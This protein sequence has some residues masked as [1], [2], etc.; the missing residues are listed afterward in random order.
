MIQQ[1]QHHSRINKFAVAAVH[2]RWIMLI[3]VTFIPCIV[4]CH[5]EADLA[6]TCYWDIDRAS[7]GNYNLL[8]IKY[9]LSEARLRYISVQMTGVPRHDTV[10][11]EVRSNKSHFRMIFLKKIRKHQIIITPEHEKIVE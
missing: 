8:C 9:V 6:T 2:R 7:D 5:R 11:P 4:H 3:N 1:Q 10:E